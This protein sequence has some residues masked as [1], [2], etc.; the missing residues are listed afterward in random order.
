MVSSRN[1]SS[2][3][4]T[5]RNERRAR[6]TAASWKF[7]PLPWQS[8]HCFHTR[9]HKTGCFGSDADVSKGGRP[10]GQLG[11]RLGGQL[12]R[13]ASG[14]ARGPV[15]GGEGYSRLPADHSCKPRSRSVGTSG[16]YPGGGS[17]NN[18]WFCSNVS[19]RSTVLTQLYAKSN[20]ELQKG[21]QN[22]KRESIT[23]VSE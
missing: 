14:R 1:C 17:D 11:S 19:L 12:R 20:G 8:A 4:I 15:A 9:T 13:P 23:P 6:S 5:E 16:S 2:N 7:T 18:D 3:E 22:R 10:S 21:K